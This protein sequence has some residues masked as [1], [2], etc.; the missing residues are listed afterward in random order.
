MDSIRKKKWSW[1]GHHLPYVIIGVISLYLI[2]EPGRHQS[3]PFVLYLIFLPL[4]LFWLYTT[5][6]RGGGSYLK[7]SRRDSFK[8]SG[9]GAE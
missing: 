4:P 2:S 5:G 6:K 7:F 1:I 3:A 8:S 9:D